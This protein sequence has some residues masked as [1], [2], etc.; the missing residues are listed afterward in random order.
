MSPAR[1]L[2]DGP[3]PEGCTWRSL[4][5]SAALLSLN[6][7]SLTLIGFLTSLASKLVNTYTPESAY[8]LG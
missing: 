8:P 2:C 3:T 7:I 4:S 6:Y 5:F 1:L